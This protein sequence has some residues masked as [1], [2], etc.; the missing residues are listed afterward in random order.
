MSS[1]EPPPLGPLRP[2]PDFALIR[3]RVGMSTRQMG[4][5]ALVE[6]P[7][8]RALESGKIGS[9]GQGSSVAV[10]VSVYEALDRLYTEALRARATS[11]HTA[12]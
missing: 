5:L 7:V 12:R 3:V 8:V 2:L 1:A 11:R 9:Y 10:L 6:E 4:R